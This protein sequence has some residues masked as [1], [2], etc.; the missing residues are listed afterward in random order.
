[1]KTRFFSRTSLALAVAFLTAPLIAAERPVEA[2]IE[3]FRGEAKFDMQHQLSRTWKPLPN[4]VVTT[5]GTVLAA[6]SPGRS[7]LS[8][9]R[10]EDG[11]ETWGAPINV[12]LGIHSGGVAVDET[13]GDV[14]VFVE[15]RHPPAPLTVY[16]SKDSGKTW[17]VQKT[18][19]RPDTNG[20]IPS[21]HMNEHGITLLHG[22]HAGRLIRPA[23]HYGKGNAGRYWPTHYT[24]AIYS[25]D[26]GKSW[27]TSK[28]F[29]ETGTGEAGIVELSDGRLY[30]NSRCHWN[31]HK[32]P[33]RRRHAWSDDGGETWRDWQVVEI[34][35]DGP[36]D[37]T[38]GCFGGLTRLPI[39]G[40]DIVL[41]SNCDSPSDR[42]HGTVWASFDGGRTWPLKRLVFEGGFE[43]SSLYAGRP[44]TKTEGLVY[45]FFEGGPYGG[46]FGQ[47]KFK[48][49]GTMARFN[50]SWLLEGKKTGDGTLPDW[51]QREGG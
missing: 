13:S 12:G 48:G 35:P 37:T 17:H 30:Y 29:A 45:L 50:L 5:D 15:E 51:L 11:G 49:G 6:Y 47:E 16:R 28:P 42:N 9:R 7:S 40:R 24:T 41:F 1:M 38:Y 10:S 3:A 43:Y 36:Q 27:D 23:R 21:L 2:P 8:V 34:L 19:I 33:K 18:T 46:L 25:D 39:K 22:T 4:V 31:E 14:L 32:P 26:G 44:G 20:N